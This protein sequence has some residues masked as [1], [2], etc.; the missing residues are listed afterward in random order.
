MKLTVIGCQGAYPGANGATSCYLVQSEKATVLLDCGNGALSR[1]QNYIDIKNIDAIILSHLHYDHINDMAMLQY[2][3]D[4]NK[5]NQIKVY[6]PYEVSPEYEMIASFKKFLI[7]HIYEREVLQIN[8][9]I[10]NFFKMSHTKISYATKITANNVSFTYSGDTRLC[11]NIANSIK[12]VKVYL[13][14]AAVSANEHNANT[15]HMSVA[16][17]AEIAKQYG[18]KVLV[19]HV[20]PNSNIEEEAK[21]YGLEVVSA[22]S[23]YEITADGYNKLK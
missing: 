7:N 16:Q 8:D 10:I 5:L 15:P 4:L 14:D 6:L 23:V 19:T 21:Q 22:G 20:Q 1:L 18:V 2:Y 17:A 12:D 9:M 11:D 3:A 13:A